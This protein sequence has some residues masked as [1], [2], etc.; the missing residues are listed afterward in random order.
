MAL[1]TTRKTPNPG[2]E[3]R[4][5]VLPGTGL[6]QPAPDQQG[7]MGEGGFHHAPALRGGVGDGCQCFGNGTHVDK[8][9]SVNVL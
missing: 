2:P 5:G 3:G 9:L 4:G 1:C 6:S 7:A 8:L